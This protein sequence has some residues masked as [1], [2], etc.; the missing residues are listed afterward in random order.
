VTR[1]RQRLAKDTA[2][3]SDAGE[4][5]AGEGLV[6]AAAAPTTIA[7]KEHFGSFLR[8][9]SSTLPKFTNIPCAVSGRR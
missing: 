7:E 2:G 1:A 3:A 6:I 5:L 4:G 8:M 9:V